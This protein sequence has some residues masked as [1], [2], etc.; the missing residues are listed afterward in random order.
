[1]TTPQAGWYPDPAGD[2]TKLRYWDGAQWTDYFAEARPAAAAATAQPDGT[3]QQAADATR[4][5]DAGW[6][7]TGAA[8]TG[9]PT[10]PYASAPDASTPYVP[11]TPAPDNTDNMLRL[12]AF[13]FAVLG[14]ISVGWLIIPLAWMVPMTVHSWG[15][16]KGT[17][18][19]TVAFGV[20][21]LIF[22]NLVAGI[23]LLVSEKDD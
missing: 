22:L 8:V 9:A 12:V 17:K 15:I 10:S 4:Q 13:I 14:T 19:N 2:A 7:T 5:A 11:Y 20:C 21:T 18:K 3:A 23:L 6:Q 16:Y 1:M